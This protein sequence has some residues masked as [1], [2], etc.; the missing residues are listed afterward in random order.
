MSKWIIIIIIAILIVIAFLPSILSTE[1]GKNLIVNSF[2]KKSSQ[3]IEIGSLSIGWL[4]PQLI[5][6][7][8]FKDPKG[9]DL[10]IESIKTETPL[11][12]FLKTYP[13]LGQTKVTQLNG[14]ISA[15][16]IPEP[17]QLHNFSLFLQKEPGSKKAVLE[18]QGLTKQGDL[19]GDVHIN[20]D[21][22]NF[23]LEKL[24]DASRRSGLELIME[25]NTQTLTANILHFP[26]AIL[27]KIANS[28][29]PHLGNSISSA[30]GSFLDLSIQKDKTDAFLL[31]VKAKNLFAEAQGKFE[32]DLF[33]LTQPVK[34]QWNIE[35][36][37]FKTLTS[38]FLDYPLELRNSVAAVVLIDHFGVGPGKFEIYP[39]A[40][41]HIELQN[42]EIIDITRQNAYSF[43]TLALN[44]K[45]QGKELLF[46]L[47]GTP[48]DN[49][50]GEIFLKG[51]LPTDRSTWNG[52]QITV[53]IAGSLA[54]VPTQLAAELASLRS[55]GSELADALFG[56]TID[57]QVKAE[58]AQ[59]HGPIFLQVVGSNG[60]AKAEAELKNETLFLTND[61]TAVFNVD[62]R[63]GR[64]LFRSLEPFVGVFLETDKPI[65]ITISKKGF[66]FPLTGSPSISRLT[67]EMAK[68]EAGKMIF[69]RQ[70][71][72]ANLLDLLQVIQ[73]KTISVLLTP[74]Y[75]SM[76]QGLVHLYRCDL[77]LLEKLPVA[78]W[79]QIN[80]SKNWIDLIIGLTPRT[81]SIVPG[82]SNLSN[83]YM[84]QVPIKGTLQNPS[85][86][87]RVVVSR[88]AGL[89]NLSNNSIINTVVKVATSSAVKEKPVPEPTTNPLPWETKP[90]A[91]AEET[92]DGKKEKTLENQIQKGANTIIKQLF[93]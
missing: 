53:S 9:I 45:N 35:N 21:F 86:D 55:E 37:V 85:I 7:L 11:Y 72:L 47:N 41:A 10:K 62:S 56:N 2:N 32:Q 5:K 12:Q 58:L 19:A 27:D 48:A 18:L 6:D 64:T 13:D 83:D 50:F 70:G 76:N 66:S 51:S 75:L 8:T 57:V 33:N 17:I 67:M 34:I 92:K 80:L 52:K 40:N 71:Q 89:V 22:N 3:K 46:N 79:G 93:K 4:G 24:A 14:Q 25:L 87:K 68:I 90:V 44:L 49:S 29:Q 23:D 39:E 20:A 77:L 63:V 84:L 91:T 60:N 61:L 69:S 26:T 36:E 88:I 30:L 28:K 16:E 65:A 38:K 1:W 73:S 81:L 15:K 31:Q 42:L 82:I 43:K 74:I 54:K 78:V 59:G